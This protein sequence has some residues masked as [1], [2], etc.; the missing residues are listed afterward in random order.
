MLSSDCPV[1]PLSESTKCQNLAN[2]F[3]NS[4][5]RL[6]SRSTVVGSSETIQLCESPNLSLEVI[7]LCLVDS[8]SGPLF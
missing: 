1:G 7:K 5:F 6:V 3:V 4:G 2:K 8:I